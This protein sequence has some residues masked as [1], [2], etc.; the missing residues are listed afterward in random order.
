M[1]HRWLAGTASLLIAVGLNL[2]ALGA[3]GAAVAS[4]RSGGPVAGGAG[5]IA[6][7]L[8]QAA[9]QRVEAREPIAPDVDA[10][11]ATSAARDEALRASPVAPPASSVPLAARDGTANSVRYFRIGEVE[12]PA[13]PDS[14]WNLDPAALDV[15][16]L[17]RLVFEV[18]VGADGM[19][20]G[21]TILEPP[22]LDEATRAA[23]V[24]RLRQTTLQ[25]AERGG[26]A[27]ASVRRIEMSVT[28]TTE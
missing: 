15:A 3:V 14:D 16:G 9:P 7:V 22:T 18:F 6:V 5:R 2:A 23:L 12:R 1:T 10:K 13:T 4:W 26:V 8:V 25:P 20:V 24:E 27:V 19:V 21:C 11:P 17:T 28:S